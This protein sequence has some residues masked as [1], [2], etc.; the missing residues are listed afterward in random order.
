MIIKTETTKG[1]RISIF[2]DGEYVISVASEIWYSLDYTDGC[3]IDE[4]ELNELKTLVNSR[5]AYAQALRYLTLRSHSSAELYKKLIK[6]YS[7]SCAEFAVNKCSELGFID[8]KDFAVRYADEL[9]EKKKYGLSRIRQELK[10]KGIDNEII[11]NVINNMDID[12]SKSIIDVVNKKYS[13]CLQDEKGNRRMIAG[14]MR[15]GFSYGDIKTAL[16]DYELSEDEQ[17]EC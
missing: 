6:K 13:D 17:D 2:A 12:C 8:D 14:L 10:L 5:L 1:G 4:D 15:L 3:E 9:A 7:S 11:D 16:V